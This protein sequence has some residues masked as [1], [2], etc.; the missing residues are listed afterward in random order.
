MYRT[1]DIAQWQNTPWGFHPQYHQKKKVGA[2]SVAQREKACLNA[3]G[4]TFDPQHLK[5]KKKHT[6]THAHRSTVYT[7]FNL[8][9]KTILPALKLFYIVAHDLHHLGKGQIQV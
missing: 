9:K 5:K 8:P 4:P 1:W 7:V 2:G 3:Q 6:R